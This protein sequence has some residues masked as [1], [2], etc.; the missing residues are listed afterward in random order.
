RTRDG[1]PV[2][3]AVGLEVWQILPG[4]HVPAVHP[5]VLVAGGD[6]AAV[7]REGDRDFLAWRAEGAQQAPL[8][9]P[10]PDTAVMPAAAR[11]QHLPIRRR[12]QRPNLPTVAQPR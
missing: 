8:R 12:S 2:R 3:H 11:Y 10:E 6:L 1:P 4:R 9:V 7:G 5:A